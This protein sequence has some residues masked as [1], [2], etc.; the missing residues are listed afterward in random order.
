MWSPDG[1]FIVRR[2][3]ICSGPEDLAITDDAGA[4][5]TPLTTDSGASDIAPDWQPLPPAPTY[6]GYARPGG[7]S[8]LR[9]SLV[10]AYSECTSPGRQHAP[11]LAFPSCAPAQT[12]EYLTVGTPDANGHAARAVSSLRFGVVPGD[13]SAAGDQ[14]DVTVAVSMT[15]RPLPG[16]AAHMGRGPVVR[17]HG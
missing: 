1:A 3:T 6:P 2:C 12:S 13:P 8:P 10:P 15:E 17:L 16:A 14:A 9:I 11:P 4:N 7:A 5:Q